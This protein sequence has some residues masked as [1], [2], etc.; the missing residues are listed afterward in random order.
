MHAKNHNALLNYK[1]TNF[2]IIKDP[3]LINS[4]DLTQ[5][6]CVELSSL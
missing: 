1:N 4:M 6:D 3:N 5:F 2:Y